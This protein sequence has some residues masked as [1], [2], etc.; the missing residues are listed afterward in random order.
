MSGKIMSAEE[1]IEHKRLT[2]EHAAAVERAGV[3]GQKHG[4]ESPQFLDADKVTNI[5]WRRLRELQ[6]VADSHWMA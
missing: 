2:E 1:I 4:M 3:V 6:G 5:L